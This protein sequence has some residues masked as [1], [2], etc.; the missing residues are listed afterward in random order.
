M[1]E[2][3]TKL[4]I[5]GAVI[6]LVVLAIALF[7]KKNDSSSPQ[8]TTETKSQTPIASSITEDNNEVKRLYSKS[9]D[10]KYIYQFDNQKHQLSRLKRSDFSLVG[11][12]QNFFYVQEIGPTDDNGSTFVLG[13]L[14]EKSI[15]QNFICN[16]ESKCRAVDSNIVRVF[17]TA[18]SKIMVIKSEDNT[19]KFGYFDPATNSLDNVY[20]LDSSDY[21]INFIDN[22]NALLYATTG[23]TEAGPITILDL[24][25]KSIT[26]KIDDAVYFA[27]S[28][29]TNAIVFAK[30]EADRL[31]NYAY[32]LVNDTKTKLEGENFHS[33]FFAPD[34]NLYQLAP[35]KSKLEFYDLSS[36]TAKLVDE[37]AVSFKNKNSLTEVLWLNGQNYLATFEDG[38]V[39]QFQIAQ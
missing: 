2:R 39:E 24:E 11:Q 9:S 30:Y 15:S 25:S 3:P 33:F 23:S 18:D 4:Y 37:Q 22:K 7:S 14:T 38:K 8:T 19:Y 5:L 26:K 17:L 6:V 20:N 28:P 16:F 13:A 35:D 1:N 12:A 34:N 36:G 31:V 29:D 27:C 32:N 10:K 21:E